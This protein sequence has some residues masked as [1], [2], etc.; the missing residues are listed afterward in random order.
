MCGP[1]HSSSWRGLAEPRQQGSR[2]CRSPGRP[3]GK[4]SRK[5]CSTP[6]LL[7]L[8]SNLYAV[9]LVYELPVLLVA[10]L[11]AVLEHLALLALL[12]LHALA[13]LSLVEQ[14]ASYGK[15]HHGATAQPAPHFET[16]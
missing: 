8:P 3:Q 16:F 7:E 1:F 2:Q 10:N 12:Q 4:G 11:A 6:L 5:K 9:V 14:E 13:R 15:L